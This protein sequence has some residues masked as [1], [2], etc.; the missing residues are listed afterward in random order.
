MPRAWLGQRGAMGRFTATSY[1]TDVLEPWN[2]APGGRGLDLWNVKYLLVH[3]QIPYTAERLNR[4]FALDLEQAYLGPDGRLLRN[5]HVLPRVRLAGRGT[6]TVRGRC[7]T[8]WLLEI[9]AP[10]DTTL[11]LADPMFPGWC[12]R[13]NGKREPIRSRTG[14][15]IQVDVPAG[16]HEVEISYE[17]L[18]FRL[19]VAAAGFALALLGV[20]V[21]RGRPSRPESGPRLNPGS[22]AG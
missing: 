15:P 9:D 7:A 10:A 22:R 2:L 4:E 1:V 16:R 3:P 12:A 14:T 17:P 20:I 5:R 18:S 11:L 13:V 21:W 19:G 8:R 6:V